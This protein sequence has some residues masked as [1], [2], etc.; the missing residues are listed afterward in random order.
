MYYNLKNLLDMPHDQKPWQKQAS[1][2]NI[3]KI[4]Q[5]IE[6][7]DKVFKRSMI[8]IFKKINQNMEKD[9]KE[10]YFHTENWIV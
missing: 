4:I 3:S 2:K 10:E 5:I 6:I 7:G 1:K 9:S 8:A